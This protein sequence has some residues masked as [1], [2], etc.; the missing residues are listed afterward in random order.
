MQVEETSYQD[1]EAVDINQIKE[2]LTNYFEQF[3][4]QN[5]E[6]NNLEKFELDN[7]YIGRGSAKSCNSSQWSFKTA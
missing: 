5:N 7:Q 4:N 1:D 3:D 6:P 2:D